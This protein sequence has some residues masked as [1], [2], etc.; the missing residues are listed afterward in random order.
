MVA[1]DLE[2]GI[3][4]EIVSLRDQINGY[5][6]EDDEF[7]N[8]DKIINIMLQLCAGVGY[9]HTHTTIHGHLSPDHIIFCKGG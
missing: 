2:D 4:S 1:E 6:Y 9:L 8:V 7:D 3:N 5:L